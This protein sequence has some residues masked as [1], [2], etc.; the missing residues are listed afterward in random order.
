MNASFDGYGRLVQ[1]LKLQLF[2]PSSASSQFY[3]TLSDGVA[4]LLRMHS[5]RLEDR[6]EN[7][8]GIPA[9]L[10]SPHFRRSLGRVDI[11][12]VDDGERR[13]KRSDAYR[14]D[15]HVHAAQTG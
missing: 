10:R 4:R 13:W 3:L 1:M 8:S 14:D 12:L 2:T 5:R 7:T 9:C 6:P 11:G 15:R